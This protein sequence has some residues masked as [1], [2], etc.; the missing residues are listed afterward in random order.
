MLPTT[1]LILVPCQYNSLVDAEKTSIRYFSMVFSYFSCFAM[2]PTTGLIL[3]PCQTLVLFLSATPQGPCVCQ[4]SAFQLGPWPSPASP[5]PHLQGIQPELDHAV[6]QTSLSTF[7]I[8]TVASSSG[9]RTGIQ[10]EGS[11]KGWYWVAP[12]K[13]E[14]LLALGL[15]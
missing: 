12:R 7:L 10:T 2:L 9:C 8:I 1:G 13:P 11:E 5:H 6:L 15:H 3:V 4:A 14:V